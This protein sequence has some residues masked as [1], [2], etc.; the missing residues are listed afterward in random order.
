MT[1]ILSVLL[2]VKTYCEGYQQVKK[3]ALARKETNND[4]DK[5]LKSHEM[6]YIDYE[7]IRSVLD[8]YKKVLALIMINMQ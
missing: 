8:I 4:Y 6:A 5:L 1:D 2:W 7:C 3:S